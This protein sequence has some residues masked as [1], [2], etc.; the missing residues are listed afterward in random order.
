MGTKYVRIA[1]GLWSNLPNRS[2]TEYY[3][4]PRPNDCSGHFLDMVVCGN[5]GGFPF[6]AGHRDTDAT[7]VAYEFTA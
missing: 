5:K 7:R 1:I 6:R 2:E 4:D 3:T